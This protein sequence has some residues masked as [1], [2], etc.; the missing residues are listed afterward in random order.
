MSKSVFTTA[1]TDKL[2]GAWL[3]SDDY[4]LCLVSSGNQEYVGVY[5]SEPV[6]SGKLPYALT[7][8][9][10]ELMIQ[11]PGDVGV[12]KSY[13]MSSIVRLIDSAVGL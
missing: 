4:M 8:V 9:D 1:D 5:D 12:A 3:K 11:I 10:G 6:E 2:R 7:F 13:K